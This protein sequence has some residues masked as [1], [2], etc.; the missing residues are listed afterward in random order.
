MSFRAK[1]LSQL[2]AT[3]GLEEKNNKFNLSDGVSLKISD[4]LTLKLFNT[5]GESFLRSIAPEGKQF[6]ELSSFK[7]FCMQE[8]KKAL[9][10]KLEERQKERREQ[11]R[12][13]AQKYGHLDSMIPVIIADDKNGEV[14]IFDTSSRKVIDLTEQAW[15]K[16][17]GKEEFELFMRKKKIGVLDYMP[18]TKDLEVNVPGE[19]FTKFNTAYPIQYS[20][21]EE[22]ELRNDFKTF[23]ET[24]FNKD[25]L[26]YVINWCFYSTKEKNPTY[27][28]LVGRGGVGKNL[29]VDA[30]GKVHGEQNYNKAAPS[31]L[32]DKFNP[33]LVECTLLFFDEVNFSASRSGSTYAKNRLK[34]WANPYVAIERKGVDAVK[35]K[36]HFSG[37]LATN[38]IADCHLDI[39]DRKF[40]AIELTNQKVDERMFKGAG[41]AINEY[42]NSEEFPQAFYTY[43]KKNANEDF[44]P[45]KEHKGDLFYRIV[46]SSLSEW[47]K[48]ILEIVE[49]GETAYINIPTLRKE[50]PYFPGRLEKIKDFLINFTLNEKSLGS[51]VKYDGSNCIKVN[52]VHLKEFSDKSDLV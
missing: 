35:K 15:K 44:N 40:S 18:W 38:H 37:I 21:E 2:I 31:I 30:L 20:R 48:V 27:L 39:E 11:K 19:V 43:L 34:E 24:L 32:Q 47:Q 16:F 8:L 1:A 17:L 28:L 14:K 52:S 42:I 10:D 13:E 29:F 33:Q 23:F 12:K 5:L 4:K 36:T 49:E 51:V 46:R 45:H 26:Q 7:H 9:E 50:I 22:K 25:V 6:I 3:Y 41:D